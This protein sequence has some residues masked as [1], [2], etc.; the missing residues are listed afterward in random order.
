MK[1]A[2]CVFLAMAALISAGLHAAPRRFIGIDESRG[3][4]HVVDTADATASWSLKLPMKCRDAQLVG[5]QRLLLSGS[6]GYF[7]VDLV[8]RSVV[9]SFAKP[10]YAGTMSARR[11][12]AGRTLLGCI[13]QDDTV[14]FELDAQDV[15]LR[16]A[17]FPGR[18]SLRLMRISKDNTIFFGGPDNTIV[19]G[20]M[21]GKVL[22][23]IVIPGGR[24]VY[25]ALRLPSG[26]M[27]VASGYGAA[28]VEIAADGKELR[29][30]AVSDDDK[31]RGVHTQFFAGMQV[32]PDASVVVC[33][34]TGHQPQDS[35]KGPQLLQFDPNGK[36]I[37]SWHD[38]ER[39]GTLHG[40]IVLDHLDTNAL[41]DESN[42]ILAPR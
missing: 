2:L 21:T 37:W 34:W 13:Q 8:S 22:R 24:H 3:Q 7:E 35:H 27:L 29:R 1:K 12:P 30:F 15:L 41:C 23:E 20:D 39:A 16:K 5:N 10:D 18:K 42:G 40:V 36:L 28:V 31:A 32:L 33:N 14:L 38:P 11:T 6:N 4:L 17:V 9:K 25:Q 19:E 26:N